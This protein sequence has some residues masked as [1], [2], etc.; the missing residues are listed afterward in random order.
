MSKVKLN[1]SEERS[2]KRLPKE[3]QAEFKASILADKQA[4]L[5]RDVE[6]RSEFGITANETGTVS[7]RGLGMRFPTSLY[8][9]QWRKIAANIDAILEACGDQPARAKRSSK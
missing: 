6:T 9:D 4:Q 7:V 5:D 1:K 8:P 2:M 3:I